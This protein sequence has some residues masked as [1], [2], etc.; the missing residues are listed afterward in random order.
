[1]R[2]LRLKRP[3]AALV[4][5]FVALVMALGGS[6]YAGALV[7]KNS[8]GTRQLR[9]SSVTTKKLKNHAVTAKKI[10]TRG[11]IVPGSIHANVADNSS[12]ANSADSAQPVAFAHVSSAGVLDSANAKNVG[13]VTKVGTS[14]YCFSGIPF[15]VRGGQATIDF[16]D[17]NYDQAEFGLGSASNTCP[18]GTQAF[19]FTA[20]SSNNGPAQAAA[21]FVSFYG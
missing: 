19:V 12:H 2:P 11:L 21:F 18:S 14:L 6:A 17:S 3:N 16:G 9:N 4:V 7:G 20:V 10:N 8:V 1:M 5:A 13:S 15:T